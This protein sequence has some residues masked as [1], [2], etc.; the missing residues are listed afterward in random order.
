MAVDV[1]RGKC[2]I[3]F[4]AY[5]YFD[6]ENGHMT[7]LK[8]Q[9]SEDSFSSMGDEFFRDMDEL[10]RRKYYRFA[11]RPI[12]NPAVN[13][14]EARGGFYICVDLAGMP[15]EAIAVEVQDRRI[16]VS[17]DR[18]VPPP[19]DCD[20]PDCILRMEINSGRFER[21]IELPERANLNSTEAK[22]ES[23][24]LWIIVRHHE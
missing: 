9:A 1:I 3:L 13:V 18:P 8:V 7:V 2:Y 21:V 10:A 12:W 22:L 15:R 20:W 11:Q 6:R 4:N 19:P 23:G 16:K 5:W 24:F 14:Y 17:G